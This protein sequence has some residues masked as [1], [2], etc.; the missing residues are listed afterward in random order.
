M[1]DPTL[2]GCKSPVIQGVPCTFRAYVVGELSNS[3]QNGDKI[4]YLSSQHL[5]TDDEVTAS[6]TCD[7]C[8]PKIYSVGMKSDKL[9]GI[10][11]FNVTVSNFKSNTTGTCICQVVV[12]PPTEGVLRNVSTQV[13]SV[14]FSRRLLTQWK[15]AESENFFVTSHQ[16][17]R[18][19]QTTRVAADRLV[20]IHLSAYDESGLV[21]NVGGLAWD[22]SSSS[23]LIV[24][25]S[26]MKPSGCFICENYESFVQNPPCLIT[27]IANDKVSLKGYFTTPGECILS[28]NVIS[29]LPQSKGDPTIMSTV[30]IVDVDKTDGFQLLL[31]NE[32]SNFSGINGQTNKGDPAAIVGQQTTLSLEVLNSQSMRA[33][34]DSHMVFTITAQQF[35]VDSNQNLTSEFIL[36]QTSFKGIVTFSLQDPNYFT[37]SSKPYNPTHPSPWYFDIEAVATTARGESVEFGSI[38]SVGPLYF[39]RSAKFVEVFAILGS[40]PPVRVTRRDE[41][42]HGGP[43][44]IPPLWMI[45]HSF[46]LFIKIVDYMRVT[47]DVGCRVSLIPG[48]IPCLNIDADIIPGVHRSLPGL[49][50]SCVEGGSC[51]PTSIKDMRPCNVLDWMVNGKTSASEL[52]LNV[53]PGMKSSLSAIYVG[54]P[55]VSKFLFTTTDLGDSL[56]HNSVGSIDFL[57]P[58]HLHVY[59]SGESAGELFVSNS[60]SCRSDTASNWVCHPPAVLNNIPTS[61]TTVEI[62]IGIITENERIII[63]DNVSRITMSSRC[64]TGA[65][66]FVGK[67]DSEVCEQRV[68][69]N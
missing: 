65:A 57:S 20:E 15:Y 41:Q 40:N 2:R 58:D 23:K 38:L 30:M 64:M 3:T 14:S 37:R 5:G 21:T 22:A 31:S 54:R 32:N 8:V 52:E 28:Q 43:P 6:A 11:S 18:N 55:Q 67:Y 59:Y 35:V 60:S 39:I 47:L 27:L 34:G 46:K 66:S 9:I 48:E 53:L 42:S 10:Y 56:D 69:T 19:T 7:S 51:L 1:D 62:W 44:P 12:S 36:Q 49:Y 63:P 13:F 61:N 33:I 26:E 29:G 17:L 16:R 24:D 4:W 25:P 45:G 50:E 68:I